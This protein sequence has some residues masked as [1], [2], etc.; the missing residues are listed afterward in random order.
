MPVAEFATC[1]EESAYPELWEGLVFTEAWHVPSRE[2]LFLPS[3]PVDQEDFIHF[4]WRLPRTSRPSVENEIDCP[5]CDI[6]VMVYGKYSREWLPCPV[7]G[8]ENDA[9]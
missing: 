7:C 3:P 2:I 9:V 5:A 6:G 8:H 1:Q 4:N